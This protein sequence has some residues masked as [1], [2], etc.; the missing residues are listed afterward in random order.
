MNG[1]RGNEQFFAAVWMI[2]PAFDLKFDL[3]FEYY[4]QFVCSVYKSFP[5][6]A[7]RVFP[8]ITTEPSPC[9]GAFNIFARFDH[10]DRFYCGLL[11]SFGLAS[12]LCASFFSASS[13]VVFRVKCISGT[14]VPSCFRCSSSAMRR[15][16]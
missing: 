12:L 1:A 7:G 10:L 11:G 4:D 6:L 5:A 13:T 8:E 16:T 15:E 14:R 2:H 3:A 9:P